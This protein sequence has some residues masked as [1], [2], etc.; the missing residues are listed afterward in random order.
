[1]CNVDERFPCLGVKQQCKDHEF[2]CKHTGECIG[3]EHVCDGFKYCADGSDE[4][5]ICRKCLT[6]SSTAL[7]AQTRATYVISV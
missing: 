4:S 2:Q 1:M 7:T 6:A 5:Y 3:E